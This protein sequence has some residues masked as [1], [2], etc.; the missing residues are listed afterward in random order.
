MQDW[1]EKTPNAL[2]VVMHSEPKMTELLHFFCT[3]SK[4]WKNKVQLDFQQNTRAETAANKVS[5][6]VY[7][8]PDPE[9][10]VPVW[11]HGG[12]RSADSAQKQAKMV[13]ANI[14]LFSGED[15]FEKAQ[16]GVLQR[17]LCVFVCTCA[18]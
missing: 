6:C 18:D 11:I 14:Q 12:Q 10:R 15:Y 5:F 8:K 4:C 7:F 1:F 9:S 3:K 17:V 2:N 13:P 16:F